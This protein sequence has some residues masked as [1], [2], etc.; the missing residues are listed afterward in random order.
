M[1]RDLRAAAPPQQVLLQQLQQ[2]LQLLQQPFKA[3]DLPAAAQ[4]QQQQQ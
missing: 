2:L 1:A 3:R 4:F